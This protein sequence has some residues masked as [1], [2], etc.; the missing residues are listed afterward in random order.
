MAGGLEQVREEVA[1]LRRDLAALSLAFQIH[2]EV[3]RRSRPADS[4]LEAFGKNV[5]LPIIVALIG[6]VGLWIVTGGK[7]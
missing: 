5:L 4:F 2:V 7:P 6:A 1:E 3:G